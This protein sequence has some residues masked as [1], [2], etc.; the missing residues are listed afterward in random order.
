MREARV[1]VHHKNNFLV[2]LSSQHL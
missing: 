2:T 1:L